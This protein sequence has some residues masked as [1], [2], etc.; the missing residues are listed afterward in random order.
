M[1]LR[2]SLTT[3]SVPFLRD[4]AFCSQSYKGQSIL[5]GKE[6]HLSQGS[7]RMLVSIKAAI[8][9]ISQDPLPSNA[10]QSQEDRCS[11]VHDPDTRRVFGPQLLITFYDRI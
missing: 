9:Q 2:T 1:A 5:L 11:L 8:G 4:R 10:P 6:K 3:T 7:G